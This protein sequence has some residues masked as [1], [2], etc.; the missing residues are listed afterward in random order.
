MKKTGLIVLVAFD[1]DKELF[2]FKSGANSHHAQML[3]QNP[4]VAGTIQPDKLNPVAI[5]GLQFTG[6][7]LDFKNELCSK[8]EAVYHKRF[9][10]ALTMP[11]EIWTLQPE[12][13]KMTDNTLSFGKKLHWQLHEIKI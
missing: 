12:A 10:F 13:I 11:G 2:Y 4:I 3:L 8:A 9:P 6:R 5:K 1:V 7:I